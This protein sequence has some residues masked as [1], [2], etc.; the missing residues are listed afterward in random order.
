MLYIYDGTFE[1]V[2]SAIFEAYNDKNAE[3]VSPERA[4]EIYG[5]LIANPVAPLGIVFDWSLVK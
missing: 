4:P 3:I 1:G 2:L 5:R